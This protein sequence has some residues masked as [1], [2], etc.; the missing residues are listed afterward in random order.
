MLLL[1]HKAGNKQQLFQKLVTSEEAR[2]NF[3]TFNDELEQFLTPTA[4]ADEITKLTIPAF[5]GR[6]YNSVDKF[7][8]L[9]YILKYPHRIKEPRWC[10]FI[11]YVI[12]VTVNSWVL[13]SDLVNQKIG[14]NDEKSLKQFVKE[15]VKG[16][17]SK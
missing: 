2:H 17:L 8:A 11:S 12:L 9:L 3:K 7:N 4:V 5:Y 13:H 14:G 10:W 16:L 15:V 1:S 6:H